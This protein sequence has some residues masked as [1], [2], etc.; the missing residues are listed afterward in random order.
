LEVTVIGQAGLFLETGPT[1]ILVDPWLSGSCYW[2]SW[3]HFPPSPEPEEEWLRPGCVYLSHHHFDHFH[4]PSLRRIDRSTPV[5]IPRFGNPVMPKEL[6][7]LGFRRIVEMPHG[8]SVEVATGVSLTSFQYGFDDSALVVSGPDAVVV[9][10][11]DCKMRPEDLVRLR[12]RFGRPALMLKSHSFA[13]GY[14]HCYRAEDEADLAIL[15]RRDYVTD[16]VVA[17]RA[18]RPRV[19]APF[20]SMVCFLHPDSFA[21]NDDVVTPLEV[22]AGM[23]AA[24]VDGTEVV[25]FK[26]GDRWTSGRPFH[27]DL[28]DYY[29][30]R[31]QWLERLRTEHGPAIEASLKEEDARPLDERALAEYF[32]RFVAAVPRPARLLLRRPIVFKVRGQ[33]VYCVLSWRRRRAEVVHRRPEDYG[34]LVEVPA[35]VLAAAIE[36]RIVHFVHIS[37]RFE[38]EIRRGGLSGE[39]ALWTLLG[40]YELGYL[41][42]RRLCT[43]RFASVCWHR[44]RELL[45]FVTAALR[46]RGPMA[47]RMTSRFMARD[48]DTPVP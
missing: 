14:P 27:S 15:G 22:A 33:E 10:M 40:I 26:P 39:F 17:A 4:Y 13:Q 25:L 3:W 41:P 20:A 37:M 35:G 5:Y 45:G 21:R 29:S 47:A 48:E 38:G 42:L 2:R 9:D 12:E 7:A 31:P 8:R 32:G 19:A 28:G 11:N 36:Q 34:S 1:T 16:F 44:R 24:P 18:L 6:Q 46:T 23:E 30:E 43:A